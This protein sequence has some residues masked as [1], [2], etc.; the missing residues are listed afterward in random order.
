[1]EDLSKLLSIEVRD[2]ATKGTSFFFVGIDGMDG[3]DNTF[4]FLPAANELGG[5][6][7]AQSDRTREMEASD[8]LEKT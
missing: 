4:D 1:L 2:S 5:V 7:G 6:A 3:N 8:G